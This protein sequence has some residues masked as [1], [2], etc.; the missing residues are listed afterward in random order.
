MSTSAIIF[1]AIVWSAVIGMV[2]FLYFKILT[3]PLKFS[4][5]DRDLDQPVSAGS[6]GQDSVEAGE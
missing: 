6:E 4:E 5:D 1:M 2:A 3:R